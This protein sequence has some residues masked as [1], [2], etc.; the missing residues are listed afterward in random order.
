L[1]FLSEEIRSGWR[2]ENN[3]LGSTFKWDNTSS[4]HKSFKAGF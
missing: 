4:N 2:S 3:R 1:H